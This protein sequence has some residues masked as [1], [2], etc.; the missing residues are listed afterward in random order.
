MELPVAT[1]GDLMLVVP[2]V[3]GLVYE[4][5]RFDRILLQR[6]DRP[7]E[8]VRGRLELPGGRWEAGEPPDVAVAREVLEE[9]G[10]RV[11]AVSAAVS[12]FHHGPD[13]ATTSAR[14]LAVVTGIEGAYPSLHVL[15]ECRG[16]GEPRGVPDEVADP[17]WWR[18]E[19][20]MA[21][22]GA[23]PDEF[24]WQTAGMLRSVFEGA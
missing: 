24:V 22:L 7:G 15:F 23:Q 3:A 11:T 16:S 13:I 1:M 8:S 21:L 14:P 4:S 2:N 9:T 17:A 5:P 6:R 18:I 20:A 10:I 12:T 19:D